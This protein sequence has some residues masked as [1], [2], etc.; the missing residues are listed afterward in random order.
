V[1]AC[2]KFRGA[3]IIM[4]ERGPT[5]HV[6]LKKYGRTAQRLGHQVANGQSGPDQAIGTALARVGTHALAIASGKLPD[7]RMIVAY[8]V[9]TRDAAK[10]E[11]TCPNGRQAAS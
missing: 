11:A 9:V 4:L 3:T 6:A 10:V 1:A 5:D 8:K 7:G 2:A